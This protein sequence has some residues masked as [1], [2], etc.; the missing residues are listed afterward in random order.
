MIRF[1]DAL[2]RSSLL[3]MKATISHLYC[4]MLKNFI[5][6]IN[7][8]QDNPKLQKILTSLCVL[9]ACS[10]IYENSDWIDILQTP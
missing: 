6:S 5:G 2:N 3:L 10:N 8:C 9:F 7:Q 1:N 4:I